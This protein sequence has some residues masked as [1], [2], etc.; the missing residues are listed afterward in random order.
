MEPIA[1]FLRLQDRH[2]LVE[3]AWFKIQEERCCDRL[4]ITNSIRCGHRR[5]RQD[6]RA[7][8]LLSQFFSEGGGE[9]LQFI[10]IIR[11]AEK[12]EGKLPGL[13]KLA[14]INLQ[15][16]HRAETAGQNVEHIRIQA[17][18]SN[19]DRDASDRERSRATPNQRA[20][21]RYDSGDEITDAH[22]ACIAAG[23]NTVQS[24][25]GSQWPGG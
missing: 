16:L 15:S 22:G 12:R 13:L 8:R 24:D 21:L 20:S 11:I 19:Q 10:N 6:S 7:P 5:T 3:G 17:Q 25:G 2:R 4:Q 14:I 1:N 18:R 23:S 9:I